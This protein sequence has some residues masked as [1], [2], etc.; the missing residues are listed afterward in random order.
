MKWYPAYTFLGL[1]LSSAAAA[2][3]HRAAARVEECTT[4]TEAEE[5]LIPPIITDRPER[6]TFKKIRVLPKKGWW[7]EGRIKSGAC[8][9]MDYGH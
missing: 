5:A 4:T 9:Q 2:A 8:Q 6:K 1:D 3:S 7:S